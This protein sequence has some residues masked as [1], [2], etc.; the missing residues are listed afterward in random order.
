MIENLLYF[1]FMGTMGGMIYVI[2]KAEGWEDFRSFASL[3]QLLLSPFCG[4]VYFYLYSEFDFPNAFMSLV[5][6][7]FG[8]DFI[9]SIMKKFKPKVKKEDV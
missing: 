2:V 1:I 8:T 3:R 9:I 6:G 4:F 7:Y 5:S